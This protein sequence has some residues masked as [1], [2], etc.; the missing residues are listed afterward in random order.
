MSFDFLPLSGGL[1]S[2]RGDDLLADAIGNRSPFQLGP[3]LGT[4][5]AMNGDV[6]GRQIGDFVYSGDL[7]TDQHGNSIPISESDRQDLERFLWAMEVETRKIKIAPVWAA[8]EIL[9]F[10]MDKAGTAKSVAKIATGGVVGG[11]KEVE[12]AIEGVGGLLF[13]KAKDKTSEIIQKSTTGIM[14]LEDRAQMSQ[15]NVTVALENLS[16]LRVERDALINRIVNAPNLRE[17]VRLQMLDVKAKFIRADMEASLMY[18]DAVVRDTA[19][20]VRQFNASFD[21]ESGQHMKLSD[22]FNTGL[23]SP[24]SN[25]E[26]IAIELDRATRPIFVP[27][28]QRAVQTRSSVAG[29]LNEVDGVQRVE[30]LRMQRNDI[31]AHVQEL[32]SIHLQVIPWLVP[33]Q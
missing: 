13:G 3:G 28:A 31:D 18:V 14:S 8:V 24:L 20:A 29:L 11:V 12:Q 21:G 22:G 25:V 32:R 4:L 9:S 5:L 6:S 19:A 26:N 1:G 23:V 15:Q 2:S 30:T 7:L 16:E 27:L 33:E 17:E 10:T